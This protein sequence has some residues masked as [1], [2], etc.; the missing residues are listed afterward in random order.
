[1][2]VQFENIQENNMN[3]QHDLLVQQAN[4]GNSEAQLTLGLKY[5][6][7]FK[8]TQDF[9][10][11]YEWYLKAAEQGNAW[12]QLN[13]GILY[14]EGE[15]V[16]QN[17]TAG[18]KWFRKAAE[19]G[20]ALAQFVLGLCY[21]NGE[22]ISQDLAGAAEW[23][24]KAAEQGYAESQ[25]VLGVCYTKGEGVPQDLATAAKW[26]QKAAEQGDGDAQ[27]NLGV[28]YT[29]G[30]GVYLN[31]FTAAEWFQKA[32]KQGYTTAQYNLG[33]CYTKGEGVTQDFTI[34]AEWFQKAAE[35]GDATA[36]HNL[37]VL[38]SEG[39][40][41]TQ[42]FTIA[43]K[44]YLKA[45]E[46]GFIE[47]MIGLAF[48]NYKQDINCAEINV[49]LS[50]A[51]ADPNLTNYEVESNVFQITETT[52]FDFLQ[53]KSETFMPAKVLLALAYAPF[54]K[55][56]NAYTQQGVTQITLLNEACSNNDIAALYHRGA[57]HQKIQ[58]LEL[59]LCCFQQVINLV[60]TKQL[61]WMGSFSDINSSFNQFYSTDVKNRL[62]MFAQEKINAI[63][64]QQHQAELI[65]A[66]QEKRA[67]LED[68]MSM[69]AHKFRGSLDSIVYNLEHQGDIR[70]YQQAAFTM[71]GLLDI[72][73]LISTDTEK[74][75]TRLKKDSHGEG[76][77]QQ[78]FTHALMNLMQ[79]LLT[80]EGREKIRQHYWS[81]AVRNQLVPKETTRLNWLDDYEHIEA[82]LKNQWE[83]EW[84]ELLKS[85]PNLE[86]LQHWISEHLAP[87]TVAGF[88]QELIRFQLYGATHSFLTIVLNELLLNAFKYYDSPE[89]HPVQIEWS[90][91]S[92]F[93]LLRLINP[94]TRT[95]WRNTKGSGKGHQFLGL[96]AKRIEGRFDQP[97][98]QNSYTA[99]F[100]F[101]YW[102]FATAE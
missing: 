96:L 49:W 12:A 7:G 61:P 51:A 99:E 68:L 36:Q 41:V 35:Q 101:P 78:V 52:M 62:G 95:E 25:F 60:K 100:F 97:K 29:K 56:K 85:T 81:Y 67:A 94:S 4:D 64:E 90:A 38:Y 37:A 30:E 50:R 75:K 89:R 24:R 11:A 73:S 71:R 91:E 70:L 53:K 3:D 72:F 16:T 66:E 19:Q 47:A 10:M 6:Y 82:Q 88:A 8:V 69:F 9:S 2:T 80:T 83:A 23:F 22:G 34:A 18:V 13:L 43:A 86:Q 65:K 102:S 26:F 15:G 74:L 40:G 76:N 63:R 45:A 44:W 87:I 39:K 17:F 58:E 84:G 92:G 57:F 42:D 21:L 46:Q 5:N 59:A 33:I 54:I 98:L 93:W 48:A 27:N 77:L 14:L 32:A 20:Y 55:A 31:L 1:M 79:Q 28:C